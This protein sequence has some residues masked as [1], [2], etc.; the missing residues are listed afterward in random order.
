VVYW[1]NFVKR[2]GIIIIIIT[3]IIIIIIIIIIT[4]STTI[5]IIIIIIIS[6]VFEL[7]IPMGIIYYVLCCSLYILL[8][9]MLKSTVIS[10][11]NLY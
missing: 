4:T 7:N 10:F 8:G 3:I 2:R 11:E 5:I 9:P 1:P 6:K